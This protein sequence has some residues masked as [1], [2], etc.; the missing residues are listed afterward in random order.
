MRMI[1]LAEPSVVISFKTFMREQ[2]LDSYIASD[3]Y[4]DL[5]NLDLKQWG[6]FTSLE[7][8][9]ETEISFIEEINRE[10]L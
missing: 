2:N 4:F 6:L 9:I 8:M 1:W 3:V 5:E 7:E 10:K